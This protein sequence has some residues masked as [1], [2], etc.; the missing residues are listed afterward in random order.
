MIKNSASAVI[1]QHPMISGPLSRSAVTM[2]KGLANCV[3]SVTRSFTGGAGS[4]DD[5]FGTDNCAGEEADTGDE[6]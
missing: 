1:N 3:P 6:E 4:L 2:S 5:P